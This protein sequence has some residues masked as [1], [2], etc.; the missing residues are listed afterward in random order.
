MSTVER[1]NPDSLK[2]AALDVCSGSIKAIANLE[3]ADKI[4]EAI[5]RVQVNLKK[6][7]KPMSALTAMSIIEGYEAVLIDLRN[8]TS[9]HMLDR[10]AALMWL[11][12]ETSSS[13]FVD[14]CLSPSDWSPEYLAAAV[15][16][17]AMVLGPSFLSGALTD[18]VA[19]LVVLNDFP[20]E[21]P[22]LYPEETESLLDIDRHKL[23][24][25]I[26]GVNNDLPEFFRGKLALQ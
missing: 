13:S 19:A 4:K 7:P 14:S 24:Q 23:I 8:I 26:A 1:A 15:D 21:D 25:A 11:S 10:C 18:L 6:Q 2:K 9:Q 3:G 20:L 12:E 22:A 16:Q 17:S 5:A